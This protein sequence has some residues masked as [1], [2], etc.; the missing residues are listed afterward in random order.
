[1]VKAR[2]TRWT[3]ICGKPVQQETK[4]WQLK[5]VYKPNEPRKKT[6]KRT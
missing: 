4:E 2:M 6:L 1:M 5:E 3:N